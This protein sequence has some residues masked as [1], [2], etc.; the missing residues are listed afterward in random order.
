MHILMWR[1]GRVEMDTQFCLLGPRV[2][3]GGGAVG[4]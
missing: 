4:P 1:E 2:Q 3:G